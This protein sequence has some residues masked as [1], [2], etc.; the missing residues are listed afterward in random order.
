M[1]R[2]RERSRALT[3]LV[4][5]L[6]TLALVAAALEFPSLPLIHDNGTFSAQ[7]ASAGGLAT[8]DIVT[9]HGV[10]VGSITQMALDGNRV[11]VTFTVSGVHLGTTTS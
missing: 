9:V 5:T 4:G 3:G 11:T 1:K 6:V 7:F 2:F 8:G 10:K